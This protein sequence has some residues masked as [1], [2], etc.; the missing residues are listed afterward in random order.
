MISTQVITYKYENT[1]RKIFGGGGL[2][3]DITYKMALATY[4]EANET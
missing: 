1:V 4:V 2:K 3:T